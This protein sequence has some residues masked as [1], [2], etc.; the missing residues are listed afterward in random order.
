MQAWASQ[1]ECVCCPSPTEYTSFVSSADQAGPVAE[2]PA[3]RPA[4]VDV[5]DTD[6]GPVTAFISPPRLAEA[7]ASPLV[8]TGRGVVDLSVRPQT[9]QMGHVRC[10][11]GQIGSGVRPAETWFVTPGAS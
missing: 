1:D 2:I 7:H 8:L 5:P 9:T 10:E 3:P 4:A 11:S 6:H